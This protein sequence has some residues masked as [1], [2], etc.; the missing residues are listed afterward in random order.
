MTVCRY[1][2]EKNIFVFADGIQ[3]RYLSVKNP[4]KSLSNEFTKD[5]EQLYQLFQGV[6]NWHFTR[7][8]K[9]N[10]QHL[11]NSNYNYVNA[12]KC[13]YQTLVAVE[14]ALKTTIDALVLPQDKK[15]R[16][17]LIQIYEEE[18]GHFKLIEEDLKSCNVELNS[19]G[20]NLSSALVKHIN[21]I[22]GSYTAIDL[23]ALGLVL[24]FNSL[25]VDCTQI[26]K[27]LNDVGKKSEFYAIHSFSNVELM[28][29]KSNIQFITTLCSAQLDR[30]FEQVV[31]VINL[32]FIIP[33]HSTVID[34][35]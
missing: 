3:Y 11:A 25:H 30:I 18:K 24:E 29:F 10:S 23:L 19:E 32:L 17:R 28:H 26:H 35:A 15:L 4:A 21:S 22:S 31:I 13:N 2:L 20:P 16:D 1:C 6:Y 34:K 27:V 8:S 12:L 5:A 33:E 9:E 7:N 14:K